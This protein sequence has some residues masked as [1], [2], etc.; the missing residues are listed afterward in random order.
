MADNIKAIPFSS[1]E[2]GL[3][4]PDKARELVTKVSKAEFNETYVVMFSYVLGNYKA[5]VST[6]LPDGKY[7]EVTRNGANNVI[8]VDTYVKTQNIVFSEGD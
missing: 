7:Y 8:Y 4:F 2:E 1:D 5:L 6:S 3:S